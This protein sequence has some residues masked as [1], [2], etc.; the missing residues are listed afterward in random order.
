MQKLIIQNAVTPNV[1]IIRSLNEEFEIRKLYYNLKPLI[2]LSKLLSK[3]FN[4]KDI[5]I[6]I[7][8][9][10]NHQKIQGSIKIKINLLKHENL[11]HKK[12]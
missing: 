12:L 5:V 7:F 9:T 10:L 2:N 1:I 6:K 4:R 8:L 11:I 3:S